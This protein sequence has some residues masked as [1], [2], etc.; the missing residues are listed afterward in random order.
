MQQQHHSYLNNNIFS[1]N[2]L[3]GNDFDSNEESRTVIESPFCR[4]WAETFVEWDKKDNFGCCL[5]WGEKWLAILIENDRMHIL[6]L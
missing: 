6:F 1:N 3:I 2:Q 4:S 5:C